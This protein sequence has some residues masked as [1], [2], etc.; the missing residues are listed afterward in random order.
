MV[1]E[2]AF[3]FLLKRISEGQLKEARVRS[4]ALDNSRS[5]QQT[6]T[7]TIGRVGWIGDRRMVQN[8]EGICAKLKVLFVVRRKVFEDGHVHR[9]VPR[10][11]ELIRL[12]TEVLNCGSRVGNFCTCR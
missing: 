1:M 4:V 5:V 3:I 8:V 6:S 2:E 11:I 12:T 7:W 9:V 10:S